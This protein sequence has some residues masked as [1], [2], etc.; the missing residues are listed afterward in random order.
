MVPDL[1]HPLKSLP[2]VQFQT[3]MAQGALFIFYLLY[4]VLLYI[5]THTHFI[6]TWLLWV[7][8]AVWALL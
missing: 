1:C 4:L 8:V 3:S 7:F 2:G 5:Y 6:Y